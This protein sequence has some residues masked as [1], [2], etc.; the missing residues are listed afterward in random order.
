MSV[1]EEIRTIAADAR[2]ASVEGDVEA[3]YATVK[4]QEPVAPPRGGR[5]IRRRVGGPPAQSRRERSAV[6]GFIIP[7][8]IL[9]L[10]GI[11]FGYFIVLPTMLG[12]LIGMG[13]TICGAS[14]IAALAPVLRAKTEDIAYSISVI[15]FFNLVTVF[16]S[17]ATLHVFPSA[18]CYALHEAVSTP[19]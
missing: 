8:M 10:A 18:I 13:T 3:E 2:Q 5:R 9:F 7:S 16:K 15:F 11:A 14:A 4:T 1:A 12:F 17:I 6:A 19:L